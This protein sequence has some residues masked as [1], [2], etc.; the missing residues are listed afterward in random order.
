MAFNPLGRFELDETESQ[1]NANTARKLFLEVT[2]LIQAPGQN[3][4]EPFNFEFGDTHRTTLRAT[5]LPE[6]F[7]AT[8]WEAYRTRYRA[9]H[10]NNNPTDMD[11]VTAEF[12]TPFVTQ[13]STLLFNNNPPA[14]F[15]ELLTNWVRTRVLLTAIE[16]NGLN[17]QQRNLLMRSE[18]FSLTRQQRQDL[19]GNGP[20]GNPDL[21]ALA[22][23][24]GE[25]RLLNMPSFTNANLRDLMAMIRPAPPPGQE[26]LSP[27]ETRRR[28]EE[29]HMGFGIVAYRAPTFARY[30]PVPLA[31]IERLLGLRP[32]DRTIGDQILLEVASMFPDLLDAASQYPDPAMRFDMTDN[33][34]LD[35]RIAA[36]Y[37]RM[38]IVTLYRNIRTQPFGGLRAPLNDT[39]RNLLQITSN[40][41]AVRDLLIN[42][43]T[44]AQNFESSATRNLDETLR[45]TALGL[46]NR[47]TQ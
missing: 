5:G 47:R 17:D 41:P 38:L 42:L 40:D 22:A 45:S 6:S 19:L 10:Q 4:P 33:A 29:R 46:R 24:V 43:Y 44:N 34:G 30:R 21:R 25:Q 11:T 27:E 7:F 2:T 12:V 13:V 18:W 9:R 31:T 37:R 26:R 35:G 8:A 15:Q 20:R 32:Q 1:P 14:R 3:Q 16:M 39:Y 28:E 23:A 36:L